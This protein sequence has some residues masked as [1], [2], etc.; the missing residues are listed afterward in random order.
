MVLVALV[1]YVGFIVVHA[2]LPWTSTIPL[3]TPAGVAAKT[4]HFRCGALW[5]SLYVH[6]P[7]HLP[8]PLKGT[9]CAGSDTYRVLTFIDVLLGLAAFVIVLGRG[10]LGGLMGRAGAAG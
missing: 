4:A 5:S 8:Y 7:A 10:R 1:V 6:A 9:P 3:A 2:V